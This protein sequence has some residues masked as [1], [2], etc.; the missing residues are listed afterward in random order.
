MIWHHSFPSKPPG[1]NIFTSHTPPRSMLCFLVSSCRTCLLSSQITSLQ[2]E[3]FRSMAWY[4]R[5][6]TLLKI[7]AKERGRIPP[8][9]MLPEERAW[10]YGF[11]R[12]VEA[13]SYFKCL[14]PLHSPLT[15]N[16]VSLPWIGVAISVNQ[17]VLPIQYILYHLFHCFIKK[18]F[19]PH[20]WSKDLQKK[21]N[22][23]T[24]SRSF[25]FLDCSWLFK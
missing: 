25:L 18:Q 8:S 9:L 16:G 13:H 21:K 7:T 23:R 4:R 6:P 22:H 15:L 1:S 3:G 5:S 24:L 19:L 20:I 11:N 10:S 2:S 17:P 12:N 14:L